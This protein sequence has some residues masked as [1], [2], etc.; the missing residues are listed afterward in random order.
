MLNTAEWILVIL[1]SVAL[2]V[3][4]VLAIIL[5]VKLIGITKE[6]KKIIVTGQGIADKTDDVVENIKDMTSIGGVVKTFTEQY[7]SSKKSKKSK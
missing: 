2:A 6:A 1:L 3:F 7:S 4:L 5:V